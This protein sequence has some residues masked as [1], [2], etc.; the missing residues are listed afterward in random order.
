MIVF[1][2]EIVPSW[3]YS[4]GRKQG[5]APVYREIYLFLSFLASL[6]TTLVNLYSSRIET[7]INILVYDVY[8]AFGFF[9]ADVKR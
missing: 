7:L 9:A 8:D 3:G 5:N 1:N 6:R 4:N 2:S